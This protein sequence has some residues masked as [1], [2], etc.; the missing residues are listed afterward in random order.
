M[1]TSL[2][3]NTLDFCSPETDPFEKKVTNESE[4]VLK[5]QT[6]PTFTQVVVI[7]TFPVANI[8]F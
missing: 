6:S 5:T 1:G 4:D 8:W 2:S 7:G 3:V